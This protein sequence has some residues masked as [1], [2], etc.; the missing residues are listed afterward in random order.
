MCFE[1][2]ILSKRHINIFVSLITSNWFESKFYLTSVLQI[3]SLDLQYSR[4][5]KQLYFPRKVRCGKVN[6]LNLTVCPQGDLSL[7]GRGGLPLEGGIC[8]WREGVCL[9]EGEG[10]RIPDTIN[11]QLVHILL[12]CI[13]VAHVLTQNN[14]QKVCVTACPWQP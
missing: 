11:R 13:L 4:V 12:E 9:P 14:Y 10:G 6:F 3:C 5:V 7:D 1:L 2:F 8:L